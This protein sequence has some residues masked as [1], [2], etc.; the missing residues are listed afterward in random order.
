MIK[1]TSFECFCQKGIRENNED[2]IM[3]RE[4]GNNQRIFVLCDGM[5]GHGHG[6]VASETVCNSVYKYLCSLDTGDGNEITAE[7]LQDAVNF[8]IEQLQEANK[9]NDNELKMGTTLVVV[10]LNRSDIIIGHIGDS[11]CYMFD[12]SWLKKFRTNDHSE[13]GEA[14]RRGFITEEE[15]FH[16]PKKNIIT[17]CIQPGEYAEIEIDVIDKGIDGNWLLLCTDGVNDALRDDEIGSYLLEGSEKKQL[18]E[19]EDYCSKH[20]ND[21]Y[22]SILIHLSNEIERIPT[23]E[24]PDEYRK[25]TPGN[26]KT[27]SNGSKTNDNRAETDNVKP[28]DDNTSNEDQGRTNYN[29]ARYCAHCGKRLPDTDTPLAF[30]PYCGISM[31]VNNYTRKADGNPHRAYDINKK[32]VNNVLTSNQKGLIICAITIIILLFL[33]LMFKSC[34]REKELPMTYPKE[35]IRKDVKQEPTKDKVQKPQATTKEKDLQ[36]EQG[37]E[38]EKQED[39]KKP[40]SSNSPSKESNIVDKDDKR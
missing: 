6:E 7:M 17:R 26:Q 36:S 22:S 21:N 33:F 37:K 28:K 23:P 4:A 12:K 19:L 29:N 11:R 35:L 14:V 3:P 25:Y 24:I 15:A 40:E 20:S 10:A 13:V 32:M 39:F 5:G 9:F 8:A 31:Y 18:N 2:Y 27:V 1:I 38:A 34:N 30:C 16:H